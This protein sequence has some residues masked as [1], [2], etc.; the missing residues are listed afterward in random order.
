MNQPPTRIGLTGGI[1]TGKSHVLSYL[2]RR[3]VPTVDA[4]D[5]AHAVVAP[6]EPALQ[7]VVQ[8]FGVGVLDPRGALDRKALARIAFQDADA[9]RELEAIIHPAVWLAVDRWFASRHGEAAVAAVPL[10]FETGH[11][12]D[13]DKVMVTSCSPDRQVARVAARDGLSVEEVRSRLA[14]QM[15]PEARL[16]RADAVIDTNGSEADTAR[17]VDALWVRWGLPAL[18]RQSPTLT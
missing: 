16:A 5:L 3:G 4:D 1:G 8:R 14:A 6:G 11:E 2:A 12:G 7:A 17:Q 13:F 18:G 15:A 10:L 9:R